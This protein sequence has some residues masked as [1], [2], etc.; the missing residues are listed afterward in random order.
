[1]CDAGF[2]RYNND[3]DDNGDDNDINGKDDYYKSF[4]VR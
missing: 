3:D 1:M 4:L 2:V